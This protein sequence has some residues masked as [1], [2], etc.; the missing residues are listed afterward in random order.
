MLGFFSE[1]TLE[2]VAAIISARL[3]GGIRFVGKDEFIFDEV[4][5]VYAESDVLGLEV[6]V[7][8]FGGEDGYWLDMS[9]R[10]VRLDRP[11]DLTL[12]DESRVDITEYIGFALRD[13]E[14]IRI[15]PQS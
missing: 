10:D 2:E 5:A 8:G 14:G 15:R 6:I 12:S 4:P 11:M 13:L 9:P 1:K 3:L 7:H